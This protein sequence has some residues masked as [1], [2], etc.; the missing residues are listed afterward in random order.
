MNKKTNPSCMVREL[1]S[2][3]KSGNEL[4][5]KKE[6]E[7]LE[8]EQVSQFMDGVAYIPC[9]PQYISDIEEMQYDIGLLMKHVRSLNRIAKKYGGRQVDYK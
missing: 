3:W 4:A 6:E 2:L 5:S 8:R 1:L 7:G 9:L